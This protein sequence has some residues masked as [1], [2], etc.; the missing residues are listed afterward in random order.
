VEVE[1]M[2]LARVR[3]WLKVMLFLLLFNFIWNQLTAY[4]Q[5]MRWPVDGDPTFDNDF[6]SFNRVNN[7]RLYHTGIDLAGKRGDTIRAAAD[8]WIKPGMVYGLAPKNPS[9]GARQTFWVWNDKNG[10]EKPD[11]DKGKMIEEEGPFFDDYKSNHGLGMTIIIEH[12]NGVYSLYGHLDHIAKKVFETVVKNKQ[13]LRV[14][15]G[16]PIGLMGFSEYNNRYAQ[17]IHLHFEVKEK[18]DLGDNNNVYWGYT[19]D[20]P[21]P[22]GYFDPMWYIDLPPPSESFNPPVALKVLQES[23]LRAGPG[24]NFAV[25]G[26]VTTGQ[27]FVARR[28]IKKSDQE[29]WV[30]IYL[31][32]ERAL[33]FGWI[34][35][36]F[37]GKAILEEDQS[38]KIIKVMDKIRIRAGPGT[39]YS[40]VQV[41]DHPKRNRNLD[42]YV[43]K[44]S[45]FV[46]S[47]EQAGPGSSKPW[48]R[49]DIPLI[50]DKDP[51][52]TNRQDGP[53]GGVAGRANPSFKKKGNFGGSGW[54]A[55][56]FVEV[57]PP[58]N[59]LFKEDFEGDVSG[60]TFTSFWHVQDNPQLVTN[61]YQGG[62]VTLPDDAHLPS[63]T[64]GSK[65]LWYGQATD[66]SFVGPNPDTAS[67]GCTS[68]QP[69]SGTALSPMVD[70]TTASAASL[71][72]QSWFEIESVDA[73]RFDLM[74]IEILNAVSDE[75]LGCYLLNPPEDVN[76]P[77]NQPFTSGGFNS[78]AQ[79]V[80]QS[81]DLN[82]FIGQKVRF[83]FTFDTK[84]R[85]YNGFRGWLID[86][87][88][89][90]NQTA[91]TSST[92]RACPLLG[93]ASSDPRGLSGKDTI[94]NPS[95]NLSIKFGTVQFMADGQGIQEI[96]VQ[97][98]NLAGREVYNSGFVTGSKLY[99]N[100]LTNDS[101]RLANGVYLYVVRVRGFDGREYVSEVRKLVIL[102]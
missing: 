33:A 28:L 6:A 97:V 60:W 66:G 82:P 64:S 24:I 62:C 4:S 16:E 80:Q 98:F 99:W 12:D 101:R 39:N 21:G 17:N 77:A 58:N 35:K 7:N 72:F 10:N 19:P 95:F 74:K 11:W 51:R 57:V 18:P 45:L 42:V 83:R 5:Q 44:E 41:R 2:F 76:G 30:E 70:L 93:S 9:K 79:W 48:H 43:W 67:P 8:G 23:A 13:A 47:K 34:A 69:N 87:V 37:Q 65:V 32:N 75:V 46:S 89:V 61:A 56:D 85:L 31:P 90:S 63:A 49:I 14:T 68:S 52:K 15:K 59:L 40:P 81:V 22:Y 54:I 88:V 38:A 91:P 36:T 29:E 20:L 50:Y 71:K 25:L 100:G 94:K 3:K 55:G 96:Q 73:D 84:D 92:L 53:V 27:R 86:D 102:R 1:K 26:W 78:P